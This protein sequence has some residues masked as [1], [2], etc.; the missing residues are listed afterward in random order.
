MLAT[1]TRSR[2]RNSTGPSR[3]SS[4]GAKQ[5]SLRQP[6]MRCAS[7]SSI[8]GRGRHSTSARMPA[9]S[10]VRQ[11]KRCGSVRWRAHHREQ[12]VDVVRP[13]ASPHFMQST[14]A[15]CG[16]ASDQAAWRLSRPCSARTAT[17]SIARSAPGWLSSSA[18]RL[19]PAAEAG[20]L[21]CPAMPRR[22]ASHRVGRPLSCA[23][24]RVAELAARERLDGQAAMLLD[25]VVVQAGE[26]ERAPRALRGRRA[27]QQVAQVAR[28]GGWASSAK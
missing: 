26:R 4:S 19:L 20:D 9:G 6:E 17:E 8:A 21:A 25:Q 16:A 11:T 13:I 23:P 3:S 10:S 28:A 15:A 7:A 12:P 24:A 1:M 22:A 14:V 18:S 5:R 27:L 2:S